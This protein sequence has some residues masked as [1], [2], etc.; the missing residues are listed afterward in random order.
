MRLFPQR[1]GEVDPTIL[2]SH[3]ERVVVK[4]RD[5]L[6]V[7]ARVQACACLCAGVCARACAGVNAGLLWLQVTEHCRS[8]GLLQSL[9]SQGSL[10]LVR[11]KPEP[12]PPPGCSLEPRS[13]WERVRGAGDP[14]RAPLLQARWGPLTIPGRRR[15]CQRFPRGAGTRIHGLSFPVRTLVTHP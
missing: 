15:V 1:A 13:C 12:T 2:V 7:C 14:P 6:C 3:L 5:C 4:A 11:S 10:V 9:V 8:E